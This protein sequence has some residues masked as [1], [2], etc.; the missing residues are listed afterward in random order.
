MTLFPQ[1][2]HDP[3]YPLSHVRVIDEPSVTFIEG[4]REIVRRFSAASLPGSVAPI[5]DETAAT[6]DDG[7]PVEQVLAEDNSS[8][9]VCAETHAF[10]QRMTTTR[11]STRLTA[12]RCRY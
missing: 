1:L 5:D 4:R 11:S 10:P 2:A 6:N 9:P 12:L 7:S 8:V 3:R